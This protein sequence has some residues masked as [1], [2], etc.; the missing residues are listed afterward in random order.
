MLGG[1]PGF[2]PELDDLG[3]AEPPLAAF[4]GRRLQLG[5][6]RQ[7]AIERGAVEFARRRE[8]I[9]HRSRLVREGRTA[10]GREL[11]VSALRPPALSRSPPAPSRSASQALQRPP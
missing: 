6:S 4:Y 1:H 11:T 8:V 7:H 3:L 9:G 2:L 5:R 10:G